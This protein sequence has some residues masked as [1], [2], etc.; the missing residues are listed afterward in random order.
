VHTREGR[1]YAL[2]AAE[3]PQR[4]ARA[5]EGGGAYA[6]ARE[7]RLEPQAACSAAARTTRL[8]H[9]SALAAKGAHGMRASR[10]GSLDNEL[11]VKPHLG[12]V[13]RTSAQR[14]RKAPPWSGFGPGLGSGLG[15]GPVVRLSGYGQGQGQWSAG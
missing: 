7:G 10:V 6:G 2:R 3:R 13:L 8:G 14:Q 9:T 12:R 11:A 1:L 4:C 5:P 15:V